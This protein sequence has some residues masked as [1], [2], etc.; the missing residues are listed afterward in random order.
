MI[1]CAS[2]DILMNVYLSCAGYGASSL[3]G[4]Y[5]DSHSVRWKS[6][7]VWLELPDVGTIQYRKALNWWLVFNL[8]ISRL[9]HKFGLLN[10]T[11]LIL[12]DA[13]YMKC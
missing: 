10:V 1:L 9:V 5:K 7:T 13:R 11:T 8:M 2:V 12:C 4:T 3:S 6:I